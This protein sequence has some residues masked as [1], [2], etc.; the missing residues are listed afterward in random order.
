MCG[1][2]SVLNYTSREYHNSKFL[3]IS[4]RGPDYSSIKE[5]RDN[6]ILLGNFSSK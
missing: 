1:I 3:K 6:N 4:H 2:Y 5:H